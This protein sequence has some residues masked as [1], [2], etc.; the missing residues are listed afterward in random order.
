MCFIDFKEQTA[1]KNPILF[2]SS[3]GMNKGLFSYTLYFLPYTECISH[4][5]HCRGRS[6]H[7][8]HLLW[9]WFSKSG[10]RAQYLYHSKCRI[11]WVLSSKMAS[12]ITLS[13]SSCYRDVKAKRQVLFC[14]ERMRL[15]KHIILCRP[16]NASSIFYT[17]PFLTYITLMNDNDQHLEK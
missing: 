12:I 14:Q 8:I 17:H 16:Q 3:N 4:S 13:V 11:Q 15:G 1:F 6:K 9:D 7:K 10:G 5:T 2:M